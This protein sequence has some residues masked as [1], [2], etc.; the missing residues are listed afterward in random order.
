MNFINL[1]INQYLY[2]TL[3]PL[4]KFVKVKYVLFII[5]INLDN[6]CTKVVNQTSNS[7]VF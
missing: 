1:K 4:L 3:F 6:K 2:V 7:L 5:L